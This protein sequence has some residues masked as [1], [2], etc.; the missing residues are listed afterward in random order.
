MDLQTFTIRTRLYFL[1]FLAVLAMLVIMITGL[2]NQRAELYKDAR[3]N[4]QSLV[5]SAYTL[6]AG[7]AEQAASGVIS[8]REAKQQARKA[9]ES[10]RYA[11]G[12]YFFALNYDAEVVVHG[13]KPHTHS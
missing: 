10:M 3:F 2:F 11:D 5:E 13:A 7:Y 4:V 12:E 1:I 9:L 8:E 6:T